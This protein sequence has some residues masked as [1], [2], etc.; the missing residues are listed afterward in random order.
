[1]FKENLIMI[2]L[3]GS[4]EPLSDQSTSRLSL[5]M[6]KGKAKMPEYENDQFDDNE[7]TP[8]LDSEFVALSASYEDTWSDVFPILIYKFIKC[9]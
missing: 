9:M 1:M 8:S 2:R 3:S 5:K 4:Q 6:D 7:S